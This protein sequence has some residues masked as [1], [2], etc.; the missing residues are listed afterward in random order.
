M[1]A[2]A[3]SAISTT[4]ELLGNMQRAPEDGYD[5]HGFEVVAI[6]IAAD[7]ALEMR[8]TALGYRRRSFLADTESTPECLM[9]GAF[10][11]Q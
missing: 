1:S 3:E 8:L 4:P 11:R 5:Q 2:R 9:Q 7:I 6:G 10:R